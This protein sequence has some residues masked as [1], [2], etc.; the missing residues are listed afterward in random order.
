MRAICVRPFTLARKAIL[1]PESMTTVGCRA[2]PE[3]EVSSV[4]VSVSPT[5]GE[6]LGDGLGV[7]LGVSVGVTLAVAV[8]AWTT[9]AVL[10]NFNTPVLISLSAI[11]VKKRT[12][13]SA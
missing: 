4:G 9:T 3:V 7:R 11:V 5:V 10:E 13:S 1:L 2:T 6:G 12:F 8:S